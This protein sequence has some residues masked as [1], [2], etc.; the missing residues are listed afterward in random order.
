MRR[1][2]DGGRTRSA[3]F[4]PGPEAGRVLFEYRGSGPKSRAKAPRTTPPPRASSSPSAESP[5]G[6]GDPR[7]LSERDHSRHLRPRPEGAEARHGGP[8]GGRAKERD[9]LVAP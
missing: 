7:T 4:S 5:L 1:R 6:A 8:D 9:D 2:K 3:R